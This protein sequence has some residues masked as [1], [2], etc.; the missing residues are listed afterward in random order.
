M[1]F[2]RGMFG[3]S[4]GLALLLLFGLG[5][6]G[7]EQIGPKAHKPG[8]LSCGGPSRVIVITVDHNNGVDKHHQAV[9]VCTG[10]AI[11]WEAPASVVFKVHFVPG[12]CPFDPCPDIIDSAK[13]TVAV[14]PDELTVYKYAITV[15]G[16]PPFDPHVVSGGGN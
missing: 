6:S 13:R 16:G 1:H 10:D 3:I 9:Y 14:Q 7:C 4:S 11:K 2:S 12:N 15:D 5:S 8:Q